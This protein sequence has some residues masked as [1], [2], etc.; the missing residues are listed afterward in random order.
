M[1]YDLPSF[2]E[3]APAPTPATTTTTDDPAGVM[4]I[5][6]KKEEV[7]MN[8]E[9]PVADAMKIEPPVQASPKK[10]K[11]PLTGKLLYDLFAV[12]N[13][14][15]SLGFG[16]YTA[17]TKSW[18]YGKWH[19]CDDSSVSAEDPESVCSPASYVLFYRRQD[20]QL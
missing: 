19:N 13:H 18:K 4:E 16:H 20:F 2:E 6:E 15:G 1:D 3:E 10:A 5:E 12:S 17:Y 11:T 7:K 9:T 8:I 14:Y